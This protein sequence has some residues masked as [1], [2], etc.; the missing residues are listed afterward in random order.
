MPRVDSDLKLDFKDVLFRPKR[1]SLKSRSEVDLQRT[2]TFR[3]SKQTYT[4]IPIIAA[5]MDTTGTF[6]MARALSKH[7]L[8]T[9]VH[10]HYS[11]EDWRNFAAA[12]PECLEHVA[13]SSGSG[14]ADLERL[15]AVVDAVPALKYICL[16][17][18]NGYSECFVEYVKTCVHVFLVVR[19][20]LMRTSECVH[21][22]HVT[23]L[24][25][26]QSRLSPLHRFQCA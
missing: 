5:N 13:V 9:A 2:F 12:H 10:K 6:E 4:G 3:N 25:I 8:F 14:V 16:D 26:K 7:T 18:A 22:K 23:Y 19:G 24:Q 20:R 17:V 15:C 21:Q 1:S 11:A